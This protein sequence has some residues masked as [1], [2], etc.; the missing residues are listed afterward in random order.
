MGDDVHGPG[1]G[2]HL[3]GLEK[4]GASYPC[5]PCLAVFFFRCLSCSRAAC[6]LFCGCAPHACRSFR[7]DADIGGVVFTAVGGDEAGKQSQTQ[8][9]KFVHGSHADAKS[10][11]AV[12]LNPVVVVTKYVLVC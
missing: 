7:F 11:E 2:L 1:A 8:H 4:V 6:E 10:G 3:P 9:E 12:E 5:L